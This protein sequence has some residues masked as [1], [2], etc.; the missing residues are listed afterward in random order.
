MNFKILFLFYLSLGFK[1]LTLNLYGRSL[2][3]FFFGNLRSVK[4]SIF[5]FYFLPAWLV[6]KWPVENYVMGKK[7]NFMIEELKIFLEGFGWIRTVWKP[8]ICYENFKWEP[9][10]S[11]AYAECTVHNLITSFA[12]G[13]SVLFLPSVEMLI[14]AWKLL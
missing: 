4:L 1:H 6:Y 13:L 2:S 10:F 11:N 12:A 7:R 9:P 14:L 8:D 3:F 5:M